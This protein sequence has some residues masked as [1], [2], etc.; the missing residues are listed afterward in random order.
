MIHGQKPTIIATSSS[1]SVTLINTDRPDEYRDW[2]E[3]RGVTATNPT[4]RSY[5]DLYTF[6]V[7]G[8]RG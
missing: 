4:Y 7:R 8:R 3:A 1:M 2:L 5:P 6:V